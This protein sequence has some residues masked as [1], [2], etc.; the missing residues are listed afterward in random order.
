MIVGGPLDPEWRDWA[1][2]RRRRGD[3]VKG[4]YKEKSRRHA[5]QYA[6]KKRNRRRSRRIAG[7]VLVTCALVAVIVAGYLTTGQILQGF[8]TGGPAVSETA[9]SASPQDTASKDQK[10][11]GTGTT[12]PTTLLGQFRTDYSW[13]EDPARQ[14]NLE[15]GA[16]AINN[17][18]LKPGET[19]SALDVLKNLDYKSANVFA[20]GGTDVTEGGGLC[21]VASTLYMAANYADLDIVERNQHYAVLPYI[22]PGFD[23]TVWFGDP[24]KGSKPLDMQ[25]KNNT[26][27]DILL[28]EWVDDGGFLN[29][30]I[31]GE[32]PTGTKV[33]MSSEKIKEDLQKGVT[34]DTYKTVTDDKG[35]T[36]SD[37][38]LYETTYS[39]QPPPP[40]GMEVKVN[41]PR[42]GGWLDPNNT[43]GWNKQP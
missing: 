30:Q 5:R 6:A 2:W 15:T 40:A 33:H 43:T 10:D 7:L 23:A 24:S 1:S 32:K 8:G 13:E 16:G 9:S 22:V 18:V 20:N 25:F 39:F 17:T 27:G 41:T 42:V 26:D 29:A 37:G 19:F 28:K 12:E 36:I 3:I 4:A 34:Y 38:L 35:N 11:Q 21:Q 14:S 31:Y